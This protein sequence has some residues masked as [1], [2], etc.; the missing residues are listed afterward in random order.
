MSDPSDPFLRVDT[1]A[2]LKLLV[3]LV[4]LLQTDEL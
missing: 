4:A 3:V 2:V 1:K